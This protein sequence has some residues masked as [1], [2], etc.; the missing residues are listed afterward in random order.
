M[1]DERSLRRYRNWYAKLLRLYSKP[2]YERFGQGMEQTFNDLL[3]ERSNAQR[4]LLALVLWMFAETS[5][6]IMKENFTAMIVQNKIVL[7]PALAT[8]FL[9]S[10]PLLAMQFT[11]EVAWSAIDFAVGGIL[12]FSAGLTYELF[13]RKAGNLTY[14]AAAGL[15]VATGLFL[16]WA[17]LAVGIIGSEDNPVN[18]MYLG[19]LAVEFIG[20][21][22]ARFQPR[23][24]ARALLATALAQTLVTVIALIAGM[25]HS[26]GSSVFE[27]LGVNGFFVALF[28][29]SALLFQRANSTGAITTKSLRS[30][31]D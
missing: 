3:R 6:G 25:E 29:L 19:V 10:V 17:N 20:A 9:L 28:V 24:M 16:I 27:I 23:A 13:A 14:R 22:L 2:H 8:A 21:L 30:D 31:L 15:A 5:A 7:R 4:S 26:S 18:L 12:L 1:A 11:R